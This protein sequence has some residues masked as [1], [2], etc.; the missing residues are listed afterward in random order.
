MM[1]FFEGIKK[2]LLN[3]NLFLFS[4]WF[5]SIDKW[6][7]S[8]L[9]RKIARR[10]MRLQRKMDRKI[11]RKQIKLEKQQKKIAHAQAVAMFYNT[12]RQ[13]PVN[14]TS[15]RLSQIGPKTDVIS[16]N[17]LENTSNSSQ[18]VIPPIET[19]SFNSQPEPPFYPFQ[20]SASVQISPMTPSPL[21]NNVQ[22]ITDISP[23][24]AMTLSPSSNSKDEPDLREK[25]FDPM[26]GEPIAPPRQF[27]VLTPT[28]RHQLMQLPIADEERRD[29]ASICLYLSSDQIDHYLNLLD[30]LNSEKNA[31]IHP[32]VNEILE[33]DIPNDQKKGLIHQ[34][35]FLH[36][37][38]RDAFLFE[39]KIAQT[40]DQLQSQSKSEI[41]PTPRSKILE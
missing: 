38:N 40:R 3:T 32:Y 20:S 33:M 14:S 19:R 16:S 30:Q 36:A 15:E 25:R 29:L 37:R 13:T 18:A 6:R 34:L 28:Q 4:D 8:R 27:T 41:K 2:S 22:N 39:L 10:Q 35:E 7:N 9:E 26:T 17:F 1:R 21:N 31:D 11:R 5:I 24:P 23:K 12:E